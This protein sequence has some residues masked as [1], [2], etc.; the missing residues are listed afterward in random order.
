[1]TRPLAE[2]KPPCMSHSTKPFSAVTNEPW[3]EKMDLTKKMQKNPSYNMYN[4]NIFF[5]FQ[6]SHPY[7]SQT[8]GVPETKAL[9]IHNFS[10]QCKKQDRVRYTFDK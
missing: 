8:R 4:S 2:A 6:F 1:M 10:I 7:E 5:K 9:S 3:L